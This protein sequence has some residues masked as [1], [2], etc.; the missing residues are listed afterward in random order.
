MTLEEKFKKIAAQTSFKQFKIFHENLVA[1]ERA[2]FEIMLNQPICVGFAILHL[3]KTLMHNFYYNCIKI[4]YLHSILPFTDTDSL[5]YQIYTVNV[6]Q[7][8][9]AEQKSPF[10]NDKN[11]KVIGEMKDEVNGE[12]I[13]EF[14]GLRA[15]E[16]L[17]ER[18]RM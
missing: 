13:D 5:T 18:R 11:K 8:F 2:K 15:K 10:Y 9:Y 7:D 4:K 1:V 17:R 14:V 12:I 6:Y 3:P 16:R